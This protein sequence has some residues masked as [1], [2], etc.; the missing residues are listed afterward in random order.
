MITAGE[1]SVCQSK[2][3]M[4]SVRLAVLVFLLMPFSP[5]QGNSTRP[6]NLEQSCRSFLQKFYDWYVPTALDAIASKESPFDLALKDRS[7]AFSSELVH[8][9]KADSDAQAKAAGEI[10]G[11]DFDPFLSNQDPCER[12]VVGNIARREDSYWAEV[13]GIC[14]GK[15]HAKPD[16]VPELKFKDGEWIFLNF[17]YRKNKLSEDVNL[18]SIL[19]RLRE[20]RQKQPK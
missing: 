4:R 14:A 6:Q 11:I 10:V 3:S 7:S 8:A 2:S 12:Y 1:K 20:D 16:V 9:L 5:A 15:K 17:H 13:Y 18:L 19:K